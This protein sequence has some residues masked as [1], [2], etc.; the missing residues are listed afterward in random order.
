VGGR[1]V[2][3]AYQSGSKLM[4]SWKYAHLIE[5][6]KTIAFICIQM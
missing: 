1:L 4:A 5:R 6:S 2:L 3:Q